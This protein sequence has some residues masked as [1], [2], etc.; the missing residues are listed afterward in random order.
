M[1]EVS[2]RLLVSLEDGVKRITFNNPTRRNSI[3]FDT[4]RAFAEAIKQSAEDE[5]RVVVITGAGDSFC[6][7]ADLQSVNPSGA[8]RDVTTDIREGVNPSVLAMRNLPKP[9]IARVHGHA[10]GVGCNYALAADIIIASDQAFFTQA[11]VK[12]GLMPDGGGTYFLPRLV[13]YNKAFELMALGDSIPARQ[14]FE[15]GMIN[16]VAPFAELDETVNALAERLAKA[17]AIAIAKIKAGLSASPQ[18]DLASALEFEAVNQGVCFRSADFE[19]GVAAFLQKRK[20]VF[21]G[22]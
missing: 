17:P 8:I 10:A 22:K 5:T 11:F 7:G 6:A 14:A 13:G 4:I 16:R 12:I 21:T 15:M 2:G 1:S 19:E 3:D 20:A 18:S 9:I